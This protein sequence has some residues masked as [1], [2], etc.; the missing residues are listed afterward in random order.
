MDC[1]GIRRDVSVAVSRECQKMW[2]KLCKNE[3]TDVPQTL[4]LRIARMTEFLEWN[5]S[6]AAAASNSFVTA[7]GTDKQW[8]LE[9]N[10]NSE[11]IATQVIREHAQTTK[12]T[13]GE[14]WSGPLKI[15]GGL[16]LLVLPVAGIYG[17]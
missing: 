4:L 15:L 17:A 6:V 11:A 16:P 14:W 12:E 9:P 3:M 5:Y 2:E 7:S 13:K 1:P 10:L 8:I